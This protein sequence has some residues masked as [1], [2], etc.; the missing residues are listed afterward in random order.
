M[1]EYR[2]FTWDFKDIVLL[3]FDTFRF[4]GHIRSLMPLLADG[5]QMQNTLYKRWRTA[6]G[7]ERLMTLTR[8]NSGWFL[9]HKMSAAPVDTPSSPAAFPAQG[10]RAVWLLKGVLEGRHTAKDVHPSSRQLGGAV[11]WGQAQCVVLALGMAFASNE[12]GYRRAYVSW[13]WWN[14]GLCRWCLFHAFGVHPELLL[15]H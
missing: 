2:L 7:V 14:E 9:W 8:W 3:I 4:R 6:M 10:R 1:L 5:A 13:F 12:T 11:P 15:M